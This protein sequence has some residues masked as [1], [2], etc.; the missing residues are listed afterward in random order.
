M[1]V[2]G[3]H[4]RCRPRW[5]GSAHG[6]VTG[7]DD[8]MRGGAGGRAAI[9][10]LPYPPCFLLKKGVSG[11]ASRPRT[12][13]IGRAA[14]P[15]PVGVRG[16]LGRRLKFPFARSRPPG[17]YKPI[18]IWPGQDGQTLGRTGR[19]AAPSGL[20]LGGQLHP[21]WW[22]LMRLAPLLH[23]DGCGHGFLRA[24]GLPRDG[25]VRAIV[26]ALPCDPSF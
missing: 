14:P 13:W 18:G 11:L 24:R 3:R 19:A 20:H 23:R 17:G 5:R 9:V 16:G 1:T 25:G 21:P 7:P 15:R 22:W 6:R 10:L 26:L 12:R 4:R 2:G 8:E